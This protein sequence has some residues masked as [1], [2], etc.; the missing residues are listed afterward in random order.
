MQVAPV[1]LEGRLVR[2]EPLS[3]GHYEAL[4][5]VGLEPSLWKWTLTTIRTPEDLR[6][7]LDTALAEQAAGKSL[8]FAIVEKESGR[9]I[10][11]TRYAN[12]EPA[13]RR[14]E[15]GWTWYGTAWQRTGCNTECKLLLLTHAFEVLKCQRVELKTDALNARSR[16]A[17]LRIGATEEGTFRK[18]GIADTGRVRDTTWFSILDSEWPAVKARLEQR[19]R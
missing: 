12:I 14:L 9:A 2:L 3:L 7:Y 6:G 4:C 11:S 8:P 18:H 17:I 5:A 1:T 10:G 16:T 13:H 15:I 19:L